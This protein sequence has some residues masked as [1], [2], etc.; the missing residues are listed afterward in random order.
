MTQIAKNKIYI[1]FLLLVFN[2]SNNLAYAETPHYS[3]MQIEFA[4]NEFL[5]PEFLSI[6]IKGNSSLPINLTDI[7]LNYDK[8]KLIFSQI[9]FS[10][11]FCDLFIYN[12][13]NQE[14]GKINIA[15]ANPQATTTPYFAK[16]RFKKIASGLSSLSLSDSRFFLHNG[17]GE[18][19]WPE[20]ETA[21]F[22]IYR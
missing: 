12:N 4:K 21:S 19:V 8:E 3:S 13:I 11:S 5:D 9:D 2:I 17:L 14:K 1:L 10:E 6:T 18:E 20:T 16:I 15:C 7:H 22:L